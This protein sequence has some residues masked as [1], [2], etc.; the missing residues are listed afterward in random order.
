MGDDRRRQA[1]LTEIA[2][3]G[4]TLPGSIGERMTRCHTEGCRCRADPPHLH[5]PYITWSHRRD[6]R[7]VNRTVSKDQAGRLRPLIEADRKLHQLV[8]ELEALT[9]DGIDDLFE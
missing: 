5:G 2:R 4:P 3:L 8:R 7:Q 1:I 6:G 9:I